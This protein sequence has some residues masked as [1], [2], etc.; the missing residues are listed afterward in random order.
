MNSPRSEGEV[1]RTRAL[2][3]HRQP[4]FES[5]PP[6]LATVEPWIKDPPNKGHN[7]KNLL[8]KDTFPGPKNV[9]SPI[10]STNIFFDL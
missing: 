2:Q 9:H 4:L 6:L 7:R 10:A 8:I 3:S 1:T 5:W